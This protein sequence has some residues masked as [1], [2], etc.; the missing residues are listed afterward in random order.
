MIRIKKLLLI[1]HRHHEQSYHHI[2]SFGGQKLSQ[3]AIKLVVFH[4]SALLPLAAHASMRAVG[5]GLFICSTSI[6]IDRDR[7][8]KVCSTIN[9]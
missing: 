7:G 1:N 3:Q 2:L 4:S 8:S 9:L 5:D 6:F